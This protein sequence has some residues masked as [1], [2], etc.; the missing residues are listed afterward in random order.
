MANI[1]ETQSIKV[2]VS[3]MDE[4]KVVAFGAASLAMKEIFIGVCA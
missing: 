4:T 2:L 3:D 1:K